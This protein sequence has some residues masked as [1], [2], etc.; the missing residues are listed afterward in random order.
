[1]LVSFSNIVLTR[2]NLVHVIGIK[3]GG[4]TCVDRTSREVGQMPTACE[5]VSVIDLRAFTLRILSL[6]RSIR[7]G[8]LNFS[9]YWLSFHSERIGNA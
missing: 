3:S 8:H 7:Y 6:P 5:D 2:N 4:Q 1:M 9:M